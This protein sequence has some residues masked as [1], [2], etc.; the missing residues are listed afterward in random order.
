MNIDQNY[1]AYTLL[2]STGIV[3]KY[4]ITMPKGESQAANKGSAPFL[5]F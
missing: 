4:E 1:L 2:E 5:L 3:K